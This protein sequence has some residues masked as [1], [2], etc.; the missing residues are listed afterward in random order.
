MP[1]VIT[2]KDCTPFDATSVTGEDIVK[3]C[4]KLGHTHPLG[5]LHSSVMESIALFCSTEE[6]QHATHRAIKA[7]EL[8]DEVIAIR[9]VA[10]SEAHVKAY[11]IAVGGDSS[12]STLHPQKRRENPMGKCH[13]ISKW[14]LATLPIMNCFSLWRISIRR[15]HSM[16]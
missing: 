12:K 2:G 7:M 15:S 1:F 14:S 3:M 6:M 5:V 16:N 11:I 13:I 8:Q 9:A 10:P 4:I